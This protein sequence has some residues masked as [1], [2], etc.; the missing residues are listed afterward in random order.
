[1]PNLSK[2]QVKELLHLYAILIKTGFAK[3]KN[4][5]LL[6]KSL[7]NVGLPLQNPNLP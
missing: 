6:N 4:E 7:F 2:F 5:G 3:A 1:M